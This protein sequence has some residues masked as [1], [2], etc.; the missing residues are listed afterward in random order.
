MSHMLSHHNEVI[1]YIVANSLGIPVML[2]ARF[3]LTPCIFKFF[4]F[5]L[6]KVFERATEMILIVFPADRSGIFFFIVYDWRNVGRE[7]IPLTGPKR[8]RVVMHCLRF[9]KSVRDV[10]SNNDIMPTNDQNIYV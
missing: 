8:R 1:D 6:Q 4:Q 2:D 5:S 3:P 7:H 9:L 10:E